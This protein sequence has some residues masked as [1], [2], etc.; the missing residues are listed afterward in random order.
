MRFPGKTKKKQV[1]R[2]HYVRKCMDPLRGSLRREQRK[3][4]L[5]N[6]IKRVGQHAM[7]RYKAATA[8]SVDDFS[9][10]SAKFNNII[11]ARDMKRLRPGEWLN[12]DIVNTY[13]MLCV[14]ATREYAFRA[15]YFNTHF[16][17][18]LVE[19]LRLSKQNVKMG[20]DKF[21]KRY[22]PRVKKWTNRVD[23]WR[24]D[25]VFVPVCR[26]KHW[27][28]CTIEFSYSEP[29]SRRKS[30]SNVEPPNQVC[31]LCLCKFCNICTFCSI[32]IVC[33]FCTF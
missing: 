13:C 32:C 30:K 5:V 23:L 8:K 3:L 14:E 4:E 26:Y 9:E 28:L 22:Y 19:D 33:K 12:D 20:T 16:F 24:R 29:R 18:K 11:L 10:V 17:D 21:V 25:I 6:V 31:L 27:Q 2:H 7:T 15:H 1:H